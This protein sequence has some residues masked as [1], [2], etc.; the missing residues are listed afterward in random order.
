MK[1]DSCTYYDSPTVTSWSNWESYTSTATIYH[2]I[3]VR[4]ILVRAP[5]NWESKNCLEFSELINR[6]SFSVY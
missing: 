2:Y 5:S 6:E 1:T 3:P 4:K